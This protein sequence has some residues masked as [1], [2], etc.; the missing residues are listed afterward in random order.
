MSLIYGIVE[1][2]MERVI[3]QIDSNQMGVRERF[4]DYWD[5]EDEYSHNEIDEAQRLFL[6]RVNNYFCEHKLPYKARYGVDNI[7]VEQV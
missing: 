7:F 6:D 2:E 4:C 1:E 5:F 3:E